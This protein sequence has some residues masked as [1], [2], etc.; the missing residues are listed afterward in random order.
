MLPILV[1]AMLANTNQF[2][3][4]VSFV[5]CINTIKGGT[6]VA[7]VADQFVEHIQQK[8]NKQNKGGYNLG[9]ILELGRTDPNC[10]I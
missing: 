4:K 9:G 7:H 2:T 1:L 5:N 10:W 6:H 3:S 8:V